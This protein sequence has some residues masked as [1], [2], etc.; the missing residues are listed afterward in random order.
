V[1]FAHGSEVRLETPDSGFPARFFVLPVR[2]SVLVGWPMLGG[3]LTAMLAWVVW[4][5]LVLR[6]AGINTPLWWTMMLGAV[7]VTTQALVWI[8]FGLPW[9]RVPVAV[10]VLTVLLRAPAF[11]ALAGERFTD[12]A[13]ENIILSLF[14]AGVFPVAFLLARAGVACARRGDSPDWLRFIRS[15]R[16]FRQPTQ[17]TWNTRV[18]FS[19]PMRAQIWYEWRLRGVGFPLFVLI[20]VLTSMTFGV[21]LEQ[22]NTQPTGSGVSFL[23]I[24][25]LLAGFSSS[26]MGAMGDSIR[27]LFGLPAFTATRPMSNSAFVVAKLLVAALSAALAWVMVVALTLGWLVFTGGI[28]DL[29]RMW[30]LGVEYLGV[31]RT[32]ACCMLFALGPILLLWRMLIGNLWVGLTGRA[33]V[34]QVL[35]VLFVPILLVAIYEWTSWKEDPARYDR[36]I[37][38]VPWITTVAVVV[39]FGVGWWALRGLVRR[40][41]ITVGTAWRIV[42]VWFAVAVALF[43]LLIW[44]NEPG[45]VPV[46]DLAFGVVLFLPFARLAL[47][48]LA[49]AWNRHR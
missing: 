9:I 18:A 14:A 2:T 31:A 17:K 28:R 29:S 19:S 5:L 49:L 27:S 3:S 33:W 13:T 24:P 35:A 37:G 22:D 43:G 41:E 15:L 36:I 26:L 16:L 46:R 40:G 34:G 30:E 21:L 12:P 32:A 1:V 39:K 44:L 25:F 10:I 23:F 8:P 42:C 4:D 11:L 38:A 6:P 20:M 48:P 7:V 45:V 47:A